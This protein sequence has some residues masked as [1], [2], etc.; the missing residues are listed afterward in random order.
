MKLAE[1]KPAYRPTTNPEP[2]NCGTPESIAWNKK[3]ML[4]GGGEVVNSTTL[5]EETLEQPIEKGEDIKTT[6]EHV[7][8]EP[9]SETV[10]KSP[11]PNVDDS[12]N[13]QHNNND[14]G[15]LEPATHHEN[16]PADGESHATVAPANH[17]RS[18]TSHQ[19]EP[20]D[21]SVDG[22]SAKA[23]S[24]KRDHSSFLRIHPDY[25]KYPKWRHVHEGDEGYFR[26]G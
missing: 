6:T 4:L 23:A 21:A 26:F 5:N 22:A 11:P 2:K 17:H 13:N 12:S 3:H 7:H 8:D 15:T 20:N 1:N 14:S 19:H 24:T 9:T 10:N 18:Q 25:L 16:N